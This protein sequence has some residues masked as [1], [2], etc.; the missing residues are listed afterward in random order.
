MRMWVGQR[1]TILVLEA[2]SA[3]VALPREAP[4]L[5]SAA[6][7]PSATLELQFVPDHSLADAGPLAPVSACQRPTTIGQRR[8]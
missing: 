5:L 8:S 4:N 6:F 1:L 3:K 2:A 7:F